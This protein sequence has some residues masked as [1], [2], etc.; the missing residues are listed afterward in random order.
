MI[1]RRTIFSLFLT[2]L[3]FLGLRLWIMNHRDPCDAYMPGHVL[4]Q[5]VMVESGTRTV[6]MPCNDW[7]LRQPVLVQATCLLDFAALV[8]FLL[9]LLLDV[10]RRNQR[11]RQTQR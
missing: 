7:L 9:S 3:I 4:P 1:S 5:T 10:H 11:R 8:M 6:E 2:I